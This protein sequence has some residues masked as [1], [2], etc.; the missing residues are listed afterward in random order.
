MCFGSDFSS[1]LSLSVRC[2]FFSILPLDKAKEKE[3]DGKNENQETLFSLEFHNKRM[4]AGGDRGKK[5]KL[6]T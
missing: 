3:R 2:P 4:I 6:L 5:I 1:F